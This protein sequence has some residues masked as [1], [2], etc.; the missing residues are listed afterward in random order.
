[1]AWVISNKDVSTAITGATKPEQLED[2]IKSIAIYK[3][4]K[5]E[6][7]E[8]I[9]KLLGNRPEYGMNFKAQKPEVPRR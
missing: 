2:I 4:I 7:F 5:P 1:M 9:E 8:R 3:T 6:I